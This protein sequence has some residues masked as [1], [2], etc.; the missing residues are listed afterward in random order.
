MVEP[1]MYPEIAKKIG[2]FFQD[3]KATS[4]PGSIDPRSYYKSSEDA[5]KESM[6]QD[7]IAKL[8][9]FFLGGEI[10]W[11]TMTVRNPILG[12]LLVSTLAI[13]EG[14][15]VSIAGNMKGLLTTAMKVGVE[16]DVW[17]AL[18]ET[19]IYVVQTGLA[20]LFV[21]GDF[22]IEPV[23]SLAGVKLRRWPLMPSYLRL[24]P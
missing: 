10:D 6:V 1:E 4:V 3:T 11:A 17:S 20:Q 14:P 22:A 23:G 2:T 16:V 18:S 19:T 5:E 13:F 21:N 15:K 7:G 12:S 24:V 8:R 9:L